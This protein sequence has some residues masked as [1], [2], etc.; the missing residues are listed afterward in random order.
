MGQSKPHL[1]ASM[2]R[3]FFG[4]PIFLLF[5]V[6]FLETAHHSAVTAFFAG[7]V[8]AVGLRW[9]VLGLWGL[10]KPIPPRPKTYGTALLFALLLGLTG[11]TLSSGFLKVLEPAKWEVVSQSQDPSVWRREY[12]EKI[13]ESLRRAEFNSRYAQVRC[14]H[15]VKNRDYKT[16]REVADDVFGAQAAHYDEATRT[17]V[18]KAFQDLFRG[19]LATIKPSK[20]ADPKM[21]AAFKKVL[22]AIASNPTRRIALEFKATGGVGPSPA[23]QTFLSNLNHQYAKL[24]VTPVGDAFGPLAEGRRAQETRTALQNGLSAVAPPEL[25]TVYLA[26]KG[27]SQEDIRFQVA[28]GIERL[29]GFYVQSSDAN[30]PESFL[31]KLKV[32]WKFAIVLDGKPLGAFSPTSPT[33]WTPPTLTGHP[34]PL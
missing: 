15:A 34:I 5:G 22:E 2:A 3:L 20:L 21:Q 4:T 23:D 10:A 7:L 17:T 9:L 6:I 18:A 13:P 8:L 16:M 32:N 12:E 30:Q 24:K 29:P 11:P 25:L 1:M 31:Y 26:D 28:A 27:A 14:A 19:G 33:R